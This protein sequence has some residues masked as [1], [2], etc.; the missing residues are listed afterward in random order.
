ML[1]LCAMNLARQLFWDTNYDTINWEKN[2]Q[3]IICRVLEYGTMDDWPQMRQHY[4]DEK[5]I[6]AAKSARSLSIKTLHFIH[7]IFNIP[8]KDFRCYNSTR[9][10]QTHWMY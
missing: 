4:G 7:N 1:Y 2:Y 6:E 8:L 5:I 3:W 10:D 9:S